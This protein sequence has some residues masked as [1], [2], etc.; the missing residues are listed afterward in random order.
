MR[1]LL[2]SFWL[3]AGCWGQPPP[4]PPS[5]LD[6]ALLRPDT[7]YPFLK[8]HLNTI[9]LAAHLIPL[10]EKLKTNDRKVRIL[11]IG[12]SHIQGD[13]QGR[14]IRQRLYKVW[15]AGGRGYV[16]P[17]HAAGTSSAYDYISL[18]EG[19]WL[20]ARSVQPQPILPLGVTG[21]AM[22]TY[23]PTARW[24][25][26]WNPAYY[27][28]AP[29]GARL[30]LLTRT[31]RSG[32]RCTL[33][34]NETPTPM[35]RE[36]PGGYALTE[37]DIPEPLT[38]LKGSWGWDSNDSLGYAE[39]QGIFIEEGQKGLTWYSMGIAGARLSDWATLPLLKE[40]LRQLRPD[41]IIMDLGTNDLYPTQATLTAFRQ[42]VEAAIDTIRSALPNVCILFTTPQDFYR[43]MR[44][45][46]L[47]EQASRLV[48]WIASQKG[49]AVWDGYTILG[50]I[51]EWRLAGLAAPDMVHLTAAGYAL[52]GQLLASAFLTAYERYRLGN[53]P[54]ADSEMVDYAPPSETY[55]P[56]SIPLTPSIAR[57][58]GN[59]DPATYTPPRPTYIYHRV[60][61]GENLGLI[62]QRYG[63]TV[64]AIR[65]ANGLRGHLIRAG[66]T[67]RI[68][69]KASAPP[70]IP[71]SP[72][73]TS[74]RIHTV[75]PG[76]S[77]WVIAQ[78]YRV[79][80]EALCKANGL[81]PR[82]TIH[83]GQKLRIP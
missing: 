54:P 15:G 14:E 70:S 31:L 28:V 26:R 25:I 19:Q 62:A 38:A 63:T 2:A 82:T 10:W 80:I 23:D 22:G 71:Q 11:H 6:S 18:S 39:L 60:Q 30:Y 17:Y 73:A 45:L 68:P 40:S 1:R 46:P 64:N 51:R 34:V 12:D 55:T 21:I 37:F 50:S 66:Q 75:Q 44:P 3:L 72:P 65:Q 78:K 79:S 41:L 77:L 61:P 29:P 7:S 36:L 20:S 32:I 42:A 47:L 24:E 52:K 69:A 27:P 49:V 13:V 58:G 56:P 59:S 9:T 33:R 57:F 76:E 43:S 67:L 74:S 16:F 35:V 48:R 5:G 83:P 4:A 81:S 8:L 53:L